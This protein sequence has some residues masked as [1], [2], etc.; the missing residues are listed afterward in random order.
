MVPRRGTYQ[1]PH[2]LSDA[3][4]SSVRLPGPLLAAVYL[5]AKGFKDG[6]RRTSRLSITGSA[7]PSGTIA[8]PD[9]GTVTSLS[10]ST[11]RSDQG[12]TRRQRSQAARGRPELVPALS[13]YAWNNLSHRSRDNSIEPERHDSNRAAV[14]RVFPPHSAQRTRCYRYLGDTSQFPRDASTKSP[15]PRPSRRCWYRCSVFGAPGGDRAR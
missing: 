7:L 9:M 8:M 3:S 1:T 15:V 11:D 4:Y 13:E 2:A 14:L 6:G 5:A 10:T 12:G